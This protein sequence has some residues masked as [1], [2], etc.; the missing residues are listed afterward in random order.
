LDRIKDAHI[1]RLI[2]QISDHYRNNITNRFLRPVLLQLPIDKTTWDHIEL[3]T[4]KLDLFQ[5][6]G[7]HLDDLYRQ[8]AA[9]AMFVDVA[10]SNLMPT[11]KAKL[12]AFPGSQDK[13]L[14]EMAASNFE[15]NLKVFADLLNA[16]YAGL[17]EIDKTK[18]VKNQPVYTQMIELHSIDRLLTGI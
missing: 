12:S 3:L 11:L 15:S 5:Y 6:Q 9:C 16:L 10:R 14:R 13:I 7:F 17:V 18:A 1:V 2:E 8:I 4:E